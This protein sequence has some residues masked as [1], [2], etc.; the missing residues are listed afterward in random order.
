MQRMG[1]FL[2]FVPWI[3]FSVV[4]GPSTWEWAALAALVCS[5]VLVVPDWRRTRSMSVLDAAGI[6]FFAVMAILALALDRASLQP[7]ED[8]AQLLSSV[9]IAVVAFGS[10]AV[11]RPF[12]EY[13]A[14]QT[15]PREY[16][17][18]PDFRRINRVL[19]ALWGAVFVLIALCDAAAGWW[20]ASSDLFNWVLPVV[21]LVAA[22]KVTAWYPDHVTGGQDD[23]RSAAPTT[24]A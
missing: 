7:L 3:V 22:V 14:K 4:S 18:S 5:L 21:L 13:Y 24:P 11:G 1:V 20:G 19:T 17:Q 2:G 12:T 10:L 23:K 15:T 16:W 6:V 9:V 8:R